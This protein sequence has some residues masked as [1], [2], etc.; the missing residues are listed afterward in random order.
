MN[1]I[2]DEIV[3]IRIWPLEAEFAAKSRLPPDLKSNAGWPAGFRV[4]KKETAGSHSY[5]AA[6]RDAYSKS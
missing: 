4:P 3:D 5:P 1:A 2:A 6:R